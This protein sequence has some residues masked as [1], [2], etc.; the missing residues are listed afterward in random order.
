MIVDALVADQFTLCSDSLCGY[1]RRYPAKHL[2]RITGAAVATAEGW[3][4]GKWPQSRHMVRLA[5]ELG[6]AFLDAAYGPVLADAA[7]LALKIARVEDELKSIRKEIEDEAR[8]EH[9]A[10]AVGGAAAGGR[11]GAGAA[12]AKGGWV[13]AARRSAAL[14]MTLVS[15]WGPVSAA[16]GS[17]DGDD[18]WARFFRSR[19]A[20]ARMVKISARRDA[21]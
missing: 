6:Q 5:A 4:E 11:R 13:A 10:G 15:L 7:P 1:L 16:F 9:A 20:A 3:Q 14:A 8:A 2:A 12:G 17:G 21:A 19:P 18:D